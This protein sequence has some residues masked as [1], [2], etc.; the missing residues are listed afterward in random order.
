MAIH[1]RP[2]DVA[3]TQ[4]RPLATVARRAL[5]GMAASVV[6]GVAACG[7]A[8][9]GDA[10]HL[11]PPTAG[12][13]R[14]P[15]TVARAA[16]GVPLCAAA[17]KVDRVVVSQTSALARHFHEILPRRI[18]ISDAP[19]AR[20]LATAVCA[21][22]RTP[23][24]LRCPADFGGSLRMKFA[25]ARRDFW[26]VGIQI[27]GCRG[28]TGA[29]PARSWSRSPQFGRLLIRTTAGGGVPIPGKSSVPTP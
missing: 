19:E 1:C 25:A 29:G 9:P 12:H 3:A 21:L 10:G 28:V 22:P 26:P 11:T 2:L 13:A 20:A 14:E 24:R 18:T 15:T 4:G 6:I 17:D 7:N 8:V 27:S 5:A 16:T 23:P